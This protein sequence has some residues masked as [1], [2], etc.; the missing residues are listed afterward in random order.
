MFNIK[1]AVR[2]KIAMFSDLI[3]VQNALKMFKKV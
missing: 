1:Y 3:R 2:K